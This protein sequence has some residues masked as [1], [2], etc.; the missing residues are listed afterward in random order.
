MEARSRNLC[1]RGRAISITRSECMVVA[2]VIQH[3]KRMLHIILSFVA[4]V[5]LPYFSTLSQKGH[6]FRKKERY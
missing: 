5:A 6:D 3:A 2:L 1:C 4:C